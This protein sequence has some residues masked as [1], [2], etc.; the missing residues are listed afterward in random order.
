LSHT[1]HGMH[2]INI[3]VT[4]NMR[5]RVRSELCLALELRARKAKCIITRAALFKLVCVKRE[6]RVCA[7]WFTEPTCRKINV[8]RK[9][10]ENDCKS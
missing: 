3:H 6:L 2:K 4:M 5:E 10:W 1:V 7:S 8:R 9:R